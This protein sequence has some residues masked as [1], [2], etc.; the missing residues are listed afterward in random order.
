MKERDNQV[1][2]TSRLRDKGFKFNERGF[3]GAKKMAESTFQKEEDN[4]FWEC[5]RDKSGNG[6]ATIRLLPDKNLDAKFHILE[7]YQHFFEGP[8][9]KYFKANCPTTTG[10]ECPVCEANTELWK[11]EIEANQDIVRIRK[12]KRQRICNVFVIDD[13]IAPENNGKNFLMEIHFELYDII[14]EKLQPKFPG[15][16]A[17]MVFNPIESPNLNIKVMTEPKSINGKKV[18]VRNFKFSAFSEKIEPLGS[19]D[20]INE[21]WQ[22]SYDLHE[23]LQEKRF[24][25]LPYEEIKTK[26]EKFLS[27]GSSRMSSPGTT[28][29]EQ[30]AP[31]KDVSEIFNNEQKAPE[32]KEPEKKEEVKMDKETEQ[33]ADKLEGLSSEDVGEDEIKI[34][35]ESI[36]GD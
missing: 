24:E 33:I 19:D 7:F 12:R 1:T 22:N 21:I 23:L 29:Q 30:V 35:A 27:K 17:V 6:Y 34:D 2:L 9:G 16:K 11:T 5:K 18:G 26:F 8:G 13:P 32:K 28:I 10:G 4:R 36:F 14:M 25:I 3:E 20:K 15:S 31:V